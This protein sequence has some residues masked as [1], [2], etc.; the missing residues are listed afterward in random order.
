MTKNEIKKAL[1]VEKPLATFIHMKKAIAFYGAGLNNGERVYFSIPVADM[2]EAEF[3]LNMP[4]Q[5]LN[6]WIVAEE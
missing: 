5:E 4:A 3:L 1:Y 6:R 2:G